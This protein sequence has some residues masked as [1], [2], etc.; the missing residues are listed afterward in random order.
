[1]SSNKTVKGPTDY[2]KWE[3]FNADL[4]C[5]LLEDDIKDDSELT[6]EFEESK[7]DEALVHKEKVTAYL[8]DI[9]HPSLIV[10]NLG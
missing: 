7:R 4:E 1:M 10:I 9:I 6:D 8:F 5:D 3:K 2:T